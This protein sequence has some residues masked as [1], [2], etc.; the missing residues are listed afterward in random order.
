MIPIYYEYLENA[1]CVIPVALYMYISFA[2]GL[3]IIPCGYE[4]NFVQIHGEMILLCWYAIQ[5]VEWQKILT[6]S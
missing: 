2:C 5:T 1:I 4:V 6:V 3:S